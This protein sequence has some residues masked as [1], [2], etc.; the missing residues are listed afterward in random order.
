MWGDQGGVENLF[1]C[2]RPSILLGDVTMVRVIIKGGVWRNT[3]TP[4]HFYEQVGQQSTIT[5]QF[6]DFV[7]MYIEWKERD[8]LPCI[9]NTT[10]SGN[11]I[12]S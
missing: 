12:P 6:D 2:L 9:C 7:Y 10:L 11:M 3:E 1:Y 8:D 5:D 4:Y